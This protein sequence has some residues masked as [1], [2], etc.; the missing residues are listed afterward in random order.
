[1]GK[2]LTGSGASVGIKVSFDSEAHNSDISSIW[3]PCGVVDHV[4]A[5]LFWASNSLIA[6]S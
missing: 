2:G 4:S 5:D 6:D 3:L 1:M